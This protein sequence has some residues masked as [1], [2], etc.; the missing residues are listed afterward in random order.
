MS[1][2]F[3]YFLNLLIVALPLAF[4]EIV[5][6][7]KN[8]W[9]SGW[10]K[11][12]WYAKPFLPDNS[13]TKLL[14]KILKV[15]SPLNYHFLVFGVILTVVFVLEYFRWT[16]NILLLLASFIGVTVFEDFLWFLLNWHFDSRK[17]LLKGP[18]GSIWWH[19]SWIKISSNYYLP[20]SYLFAMP[21]SLILLLLASS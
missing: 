15:E 21:L 13:V 2:Y 18:N 17:Q 10:P 1:I 6:E 5:I 3:I 16:D 8:G 20:T 4:F 11:D 19:K 9:G 12:K 14:V 7:K